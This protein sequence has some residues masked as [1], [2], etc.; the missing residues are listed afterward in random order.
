ME[1]LTVGLGALA[2][3]LGFPLLLLG[4]LALL[5]ALEHWM[6]ESHE[7]AARVQALVEDRR[8]VHEV[9]A[10]VATLLAQLADRHEGP[11]HGQGRDATED[12]ASVGERDESPP[13]EGR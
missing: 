4:M 1:Q 7:R 12:G 10:A 11:P 9:E 2:L 5:G 6:L 8:E 3:L 13:R